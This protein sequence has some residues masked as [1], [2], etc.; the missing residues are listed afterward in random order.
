VQW[1]ISKITPI[2]KLFPPIRVATDIRTIAVSSA[3]SKITQKFI[4]RHYNDFLL[5]TQTL[6]SLDVFVVVQLIMLC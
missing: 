3:I 5:I 4:T 6:T 2:P 1:K